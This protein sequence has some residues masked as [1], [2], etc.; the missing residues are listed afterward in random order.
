MN[1]HLKYFAQSFAVG[2]IT[3]G[4]IVLLMA[5]INT[6]LGLNVF[7]GMVAVMMVTFIGV[8]VRG[9]MGFNDE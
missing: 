4:V 5:F 1:D 3:I 8:L 6:D 2:A 7:L 9:L